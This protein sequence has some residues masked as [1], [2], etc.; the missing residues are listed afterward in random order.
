[1]KLKTKMLL[2][3]MAVTLLNAYTLNAAPAP[4]F[5]SPQMMSSPYQFPPQ[6]F[7]ENMGGNG[8][9]PSQPA[10]MPQNP[11]VQQRAPLNRPPIY[12]G[13]QQ[14]RP[15]PQPNMNF[16]QFPNNNVMP[17]TTNGNNGFNPFSGNNMPF[18][19]NKSNSFMP[20]NPMPNM[21]G[22]NNANNFPFFGNRNTK[23]RKKAWGTKRNIWPD[24]YTDFT[25]EAWDT[26]T[27]A[28]RD[29]GYMP[30]GWRFPYISTPDPVTV[31]DAITNQFPPIAEEA[32]NMMDFSDWGIFDK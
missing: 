20:S 13:Q 28:P 9:P 2:T 32:G 16:P 30:G 6:Q 11:M 18:M 25:D 27:R 7:P 4:V 24:F 26:V 23:K 31:S 1:M 19:N 10:Y 22:N 5:P 14:F 3:T 15:A 12:Q 21:F 17:F 8:M 29:L